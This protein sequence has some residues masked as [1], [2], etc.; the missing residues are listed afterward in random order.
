MPDT[1]T[2]SLEMVIGSFACYSTNKALH[3]LRLDHSI[4]LT[5]GFDSLRHWSKN[6]VNPWSEAFVTDESTGSLIRSDR[7][8]NPRIPSLQQTA[9]FQARTSGPGLPATFRSHVR[10]YH[11]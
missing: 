2:S 1:F 10:L 8:R 3:A 7:I 9:G 11:S 5:T 6:A 4:S